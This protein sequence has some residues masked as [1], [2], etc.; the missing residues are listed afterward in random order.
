VVRENGTEVSREGTASIFSVEENAK[1]ETNKND[2]KNRAWL[3]LNTRYVPLKCG[4]VEF[5]YYDLINS[6]RS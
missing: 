1:Q 3:P 4:N 5:G 6:K 2:V